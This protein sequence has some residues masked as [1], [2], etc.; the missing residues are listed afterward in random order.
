MD[1]TSEDFRSGLDSDLTEIQADY[2]ARGKMIAFVDSS[3]LGKPFPEGFFMPLAWPKPSRAK[4]QVRDVAVLSIKEILSKA[5]HRAR[6]RTR[7]ERS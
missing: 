7:F 4:W 1:F 6:L 5:S 2:V 3:P